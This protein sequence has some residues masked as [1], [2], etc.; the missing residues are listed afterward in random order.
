MR[1]SMMRERAGVILSLINECRKCLHQENISAC[2]FSFRNTLEKSL[3]TKMIQSDEKEI[4]EEINKFQQE[5]SSHKAFKAAYGPVTF[6]DNDYRTTLFFI[7]QLLGVVEEAASDGTDHDHPADGEPDGELLRAPIELDAAAI[8]QLV[9]IATKFINEGEIDKARLLIKNDERLITAIMVAY[10]RAGIRHRK[11]S[12]LDQAIVAFKKAL[13]VCEDD[14]GLYYN[15]AR[16]YMEKKELET[17][18]QMITCA[19]NINPDFKEGQDMMKSIQAHKSK[20]LHSTAQD[21]S[22]D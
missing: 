1:E 19:M 10:N 9:A 14:E 21:V 17:A 22:V 7:N 16:V 3:T 8:E 13:L 2:L 5:L 4:H 6:M 11:E 12:N 18:E 15:L 20:S